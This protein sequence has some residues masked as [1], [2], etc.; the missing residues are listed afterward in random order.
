[1]KVCVCVCHG[2]YRLL[3]SFRLPLG[4]GFK[5]TTCFDFLQPPKAKGN[6]VKVNKEEVVVNGKQL[7]R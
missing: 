2:S 6:E 1:M 3:G 5:L 4:C 7:S